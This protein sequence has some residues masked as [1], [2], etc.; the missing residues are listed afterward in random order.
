VRDRIY[1]VGRGGWQYDRA[2][3]SDGLGQFLGDRLSAWRDGRLSGWVLAI[4]VVLCHESV[5]HTPW[6]DGSIE[7]AG[8]GARDV[9]PTAISAWRAADGGGSRANA[10]LDDLDLVC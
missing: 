9:Q 6:A 1:S 3:T 4:H 8:N 10:A 7:T 5:N 2:R